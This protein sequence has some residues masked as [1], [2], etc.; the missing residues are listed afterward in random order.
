MEMTW[1]R[2]VAL[3]AAIFALTGIYAASFL[4]FEDQGVFRRAALTGGVAAGLAWMVFGGALLAS[5]GLHK[6]PILVWADICLKTMLVGNGLMMIGAVANLAFFGPAGGAFDVAARCLHPA[7]LAAADAAMALRF[8]RL[9][10]AE[11]ASLGL[12]LGLYL[13]ALN[14][15]FLAILAAFAG[16]GWM[17]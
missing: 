9:A 15:V 6:I 3:G 7:I 1:T 8:T 16:L 2:R 4:V 13:G 12:A 5:R 17:A 10:R 14:G 11:G